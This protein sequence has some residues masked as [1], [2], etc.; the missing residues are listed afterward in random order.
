MGKSILKHKKQIRALKKLFAAMEPTREDLTLA[1]YVDLIAGGREG[2][3]I[4]LAGVQRGPRY[5]EG[6]IKNVVV[7]LFNGGSLPEMQAAEQDMDFYDSAGFEKS[8]EITAHVKTTGPNATT[9]VRPPA[10]FVRSKTDT[11]IDL[12]DGQQRSLAISSSFIG[13]FNGKELYLNLDTIQYCDDNDVY[14][15]NTSDFS[16]YDNSEVIPKNA[17]K[18]KLLMDLDE[19]SPSEVVSELGLDAEYEDQLKKFELIVEMIMHALFVRKPI[20][21]KKFKNLTPDQVTN[22]F[23]LLNST[24]VAVS[25]VERI[26][27]NIAS[28]KGGDAMMSEASRLLGGLLVRYGVNNT[29]TAKDYVTRSL[30]TIVSPEKGKMAHNAKAI[31]DGKDPFEEYMSDYKYFVSILPDMI[32]AID[33]LLYSNGRI[34]KSIDEHFRHVLSDEDT[35]SVLVILLTVAYEAIKNDSKMFSSNISGNKID[36][37]LDILSKDVLLAD[38]LLRL[39]IE[40]AGRYQKIVYASRAMVYGVKSNDT[41]KIGKKFKPLSFKGVGLGY[42]YLNDS[43]LLKVGVVPKLFDKSNDQATLKILSVFNSEFNTTNGYDIEHIGSTALQGKQDFDAAIANELGNNYPG[44]YQFF[45]DVQDSTVNKCM[46]LGK[47]NKSLPTTIKAKVQKVMESHSDHLATVLSEYGIA[48]FDIGDID[49][50][51]MEHFPFIMF[52]QYC[53]HV[54][55]QQLH[56]KRMLMNMNQPIPNNIAMADMLDMFIE[57]H[58]TDNIGR[59]KYGNQLTQELRKTYAQYGHI[60]G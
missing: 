47:V 9:L 43:V 44:L 7:T 16:F 27:A 46:L 60:I 6:R 38:K 17:I 20:S 5:D 3:S 59:A 48:N 29:V 10:V 56:N 23:N 11:V 18:V 25:H 1:E 42:E 12:V 30:I 8:Y 2:V 49:A 4:A 31:D 26:Y 40:K 50:L 55:R 54:R 36:E 34:R 32:S 33:K 22:M 28:K 51:N 19:L 53:R 24:S 39:K 35:A 13:S 21:I 52:A 45:I 14:V 57:Y 15:F 37:L 41:V 58:L